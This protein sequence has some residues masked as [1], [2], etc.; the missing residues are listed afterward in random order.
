[1]TTPAAQQPHLPGIPLPD[2]PGQATRTDAVEDF[3]GQHRRPVGARAPRPSRRRTRKRPPRARRIA[4]L[5]LPELPLQILLRDHPHWRGHPVALVPEDAPQAPLVRV[6]RAA[7]KLR[8][9]TGMR[10]GAARSLVPD[11]RAGV[12]PPGRVDAVVDEL[13]RALRTFSPHVEADRERPGVFFVDPDG[14][15]GLYGDDATWAETVHRYLEGRG[16][17]ASLVVGFDRGLAQALAQHRY[18]AMARTPLVAGSPEDEADQAAAIPL[19]HLDLDPELRD[20]LELLGVDRLGAMMALSGAELVDRFGAPAADAV[21]RFGALAPANRGR[22]DTRSVLPVQGERVVDPV[23][24]TTQ[25]DPPDRDLGRLLFTLKGLLHEAVRQSVARH[26]AVAALDV[27]L[28][29]ERYGPVADDPRVTTRITPA[30][31]TADERVLLELLRLR[32]GE[33]SLPTPVEE[34]SLSVVGAAAT[35][36]QLAFWEGAG[37]R[38]RRAGD[39]ALARVRALFGD[40]AVV[41][42]VLRSGHLPEARFA[43]EQ[44]RTM[45]PAARRAANGDQRQGPPPGRGGAPGFR[46]RIVRDG[47]LP[48]AGLVRRLYARPK[49]LATRSISPRPD[50]REDPGDDD[51]R[52]RRPDPPP[53]SAQPGLFDRLGGHPGSGDGAPASPRDGGDAAISDGAPPKLLET[54]DGQRLRLLGP[55]RLSG[56]WWMREVARDYYYAES[57]AG[58]LLWVYFDRRRQRWFVQGEVD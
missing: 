32:L 30:E 25:V 9:R 40:D 44:L 22:T 17:L 6:N 13:T 43:W 18:A 3:F 4:C 2:D 11:L 46:P 56:G 16:F 27:A 58:A 31:P 1:M 48:D 15:D 53:P 14:L 38:D 19:G 39:R 34:L 50:P 45:P 8:L 42:P 5:E 20:G 33:L 57:G 47:D 49:P 7:R 36:D 41:R 37:G 28:T 52:E 54:A 55:H 35:G 10:Y 29:L 23:T 26:Q 21:A 24:T 51:A 12:V